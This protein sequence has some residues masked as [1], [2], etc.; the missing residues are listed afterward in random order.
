V[1]SALAVAGTP[2]IMQGMKRR[3]KT[4]SQE[5]SGYT[6]YW[7]GCQLSGDF[8][9]PLSRHGGREYQ[10]FCAEH[11]AQFNKSWDFFE[12]M[13]QEEIYQHQKEAYLGHHPTWKQQATTPHLDETLRSAYARMF[14]DKPN[15]SVAAPPISNQSKEALALLDLEHP[16]TREH[17]KKTYRVLVKKY[18]PDANGG[19]KKA[20]ETFKRIAIAYDY[21]IEHYHHA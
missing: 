19:S 16:A 21:L 20:E 13:N 17:I 18:H 11:I 14:G 3:N 8:K 4:T 10:W 1:I 12:G 5:T 7:F 15:H 2:A 6:C 9:A